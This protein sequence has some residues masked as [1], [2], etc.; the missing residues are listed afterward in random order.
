MQVGVKTLLCKLS[1]RDIEKMPKVKRMLRYLLGAPT[2]AQKFAW[3]KM[4]HE[5]LV[6]VDLDLK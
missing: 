6:F 5:V 4:L 3:Q 2:V 1:A